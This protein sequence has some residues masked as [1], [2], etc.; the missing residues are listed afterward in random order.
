VVNACTL[1]KLVLVREAQHTKAAHAACTTANHSSR[2]KES[3]FTLR[4]HMYGG[5]KNLASGKSERNSQSCLRNPHLQDK[6]RSRSNNIYLKASCT[7]WY[8]GTV[9]TRAAS[10]SCRGGL[11]C[12]CLHI[13]DKLAENIYLTFIA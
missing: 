11:A 9:C 13:A 12:I 3:E 5:S 8:R 7:R 4:K 1:S 2:H 10:C 6:C